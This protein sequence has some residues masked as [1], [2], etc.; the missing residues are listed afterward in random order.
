M[1]PTS[2]N[3]E[4]DVQ[5][6]TAS[7]WSCNDRRLLLCGI[8]QQLVDFDQY[9]VTILFYNSCSGVL[10]KRMNS[11]IS[12]IGTA[13]AKNLKRGHYTSFETKLG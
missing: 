5:T 10:R 11:D 8:L 6:T 2:S 7:R 12:S 3:S 13:E 9:C 4:A 1:S